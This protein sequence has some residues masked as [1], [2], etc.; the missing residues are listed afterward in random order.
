MI[1]RRAGAAAAETR[2]ATHASDRRR[3]V[4]AA[5]TAQERGRRLGKLPDRRRD[6]RSWRQLRDQRLDL[7]PGLAR[8]AG[9]HRLVVLRREVRT[10]HP[11]GSERHRAG[12][13]PV[14]DHRED[15]DTRAP[16]ICGCTRRPR[17]GGARPCS[18][19][20][21]SRAR[22]RRK[23]KAGYRAPP[24]ARR[25][26]PWPRAP[27]RRARRGARGDRDPRGRRRERTCS[28]SCA[29]FI[30]VIFAAARWLARAPG[31]TRSASS[32]AIE[33]PRAGSGAERPERAQ[34][35]IVKIRARG[36]GSNAWEPRSESNARAK[37]FVEAKP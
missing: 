13:E 3:R 29:L 15:G 8:G 18:S 25:A 26:R 2:S 7:A 33:G 19:R 1:G 14:E 11:H 30:T 35:A 4:G 17:R 22:A 31:R 6:I 12:G 32:A 21:A 24:G 9:Q 27:C 20:R 23:E 34:M 36:I 37:Y 28:Y 5:G 10:Q 16:R